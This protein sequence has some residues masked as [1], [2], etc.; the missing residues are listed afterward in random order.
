MLNNLYNKD[1]M[2]WKII[3]KI[4]KS[5]AAKD[6]LLGNFPIESILLISVYDTCNQLNSILLLYI[7]KYLCCMDY[8]KVSHVV[9][10]VVI[11]N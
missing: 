6:I 2:D 8:F 3:N 4:W 11:V 7:I 5:L 10:V 1:L 9:V